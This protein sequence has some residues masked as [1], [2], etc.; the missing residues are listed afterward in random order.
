MKICP[1]CNQH[2]NTQLHFGNLFQLTTHLC[3]NCL[4]Q[5]EGVSGCP[6]CG[7]KDT[8]TLCE[9]CLSWKKL[10]IE[11]KNTAL[12]YYNGFAK[13]LIEKIKFSGNLRLLNAFKD[14]IKGQFKKGDRYSIPI[15]IHERKWKERGFNQALAIARLLPYPILDCF[16][17]N[18]DITQSKRKREE[19]LLARD[20]FSLKEE[21]FRLDGKKIILVD[22]IYT[23]GS[24]IH[25]I[26]RICQEIG[27]SEITSF[28]VFRS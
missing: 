9:D 22:D 20:D 15:P 5:L 8:T 27:A 3:L 4:S 26:A 14:E 19:R 12:Y 6:Y 2:L 7:K 11:I 1:I 23:T 28:T 10:G 24:T 16:K 17:K 21:G 25:Q 18:E 13:D